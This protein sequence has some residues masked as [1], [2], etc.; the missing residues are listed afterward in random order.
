[1]ARSR[2]NDR[3]LRSNHS[4]PSLPPLVGAP[5]IP[6][7]MRP[8]RP[9]SIQPAGRWQRTLDVIADGW[10]RRVVESQHERFWPVF[11]LR[12]TFDGEYADVHGEWAGYVGDAIVRLGRLAPDSVIARH[13]STWLEHVLAS[14]DPD[15]Y[16]GI[17]RPS[18]RWQHVFEVWSQDRLLQALLYEYEHSGDARVLDA[19]LRAARCLARN[20]RTDW[21]RGVYSRAKH[22]PGPYQAGHSLNVVH[23]L[24]RLYE[25]T[26]DA[27]LRALAIEL[28][29][30]FDRGGSDISASGLLICEVL[31]THIVT[32][33]EH[34]SIPATMY[35]H[36]G[37]GRY[38]D[39]SMR[40]Y[41][42]LRAQ[43]LATGTPSG[44]E[45]TYGRAPR[46]YT[47]HCG[48]IE[49]AISCDRLAQ[50]TGLVHFAD[51][52]ERAM[53]NAYFAGKSPD[54]V[55][56]CYNHAPNQVVATNA[57]GPYEDNWDQ[58]M[59]RNHYSTQHDPRCCNAN[60]SRGFP[61]FVDNAVAAAADGA[62]T[63]VHY[64][65]MRV[66]AELG[67]A[68][69]VRCDVDTDYPFEDDVRIEV[70]PSRKTRMPLRLRIPG[71]CR[72]AT[73][74]VNGKDA[75]VE[76]LPGRFAKID[77]LWA[78]GD[79]IELHF[80]VPIRL[81]WYHDSHYTVPGAA[82]IRGPLTYCLPIRERWERI[83]LDDAGP[84]GMD[85]AWNVVPADDAAWN[86]AL[87]LDP[88][89]PERSLTL[90]RQREP[91]GSLPWQHAPIGLRGRARAVRG[92]RTD[93]V[94]GHPQT[95][96]LPQG[97]LRLEA[98]ARDVTLV[99]FGFTHL[100][101]TYLPIVGVEDK[102][103]ALRCGAGVATD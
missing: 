11:W 35:T 88:L 33:C 16:L 90:V 102:A 18:H 25:R 17:N 84:H 91:R 39:A 81:D 54:G 4:R 34:L 53:L 43:V 72:G 50:I 40:A 82:V 70:R 37:N 93:T 60:T 20:V 30:D 65:P 32:V 22:L 68:G 42:M 98:E 9:G 99:P 48:V 45:F 14:Q 2:S 23:P 61:W 13:R 26:G 46:K 76:A 29:E 41:R 97:P 55:T 10:L 62:L 103:A 75:G 79:V 49:W 47:E 63:F 83:A 80:D 24:L 87:E 74:R 69:V 77:R 5:L 36:T 12:N 57:S 38:L 3:S 19:C 78:P 56:I 73:V 6:H 1:M 89:E 51:A 100:H 59:F 8:L 31:M 86:V 96:A 28:Y 66:E 44:N 94:N 58:G 7:A 85:E 15:G 92:W 71:W 52:A 67:E 64:G 101:M 21:F 27:D 95:P